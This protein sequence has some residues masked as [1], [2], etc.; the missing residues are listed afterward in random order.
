MSRSSE[1]T[2]RGWLAW[3]PRSE[4]SLGRRRPGRGLRLPAPARWRWSWWRPWSALGAG[5]LVGV[6]GGVLQWQR[7]RTWFATGGDSGPR[8]QWVVRTA[9][10]RR[11]RGYAGSAP[12][13]VPGS[14]PGSAPW[15]ARAF[16]SRSSRPKDADADARSCSCPRD[17]RALIAPGPAARDTPRGRPAA[18]AA[19]VSRTDRWHRS[20]A[21]RDRSPPGP[22]ACRPRSSPA[23]PRRTRPARH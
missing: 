18:C 22:R 20:R 4:L 8:V 7:S 23:R 19:P 5:A 15:P 2:P 21:D 17:P 12:G 6:T 13:S 1:P 16:P 9:A 3:R 10:S 11:W 14:V